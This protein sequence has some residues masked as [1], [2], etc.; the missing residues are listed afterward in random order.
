MHYTQL[1]SKYLPVV[2]ILLKRSLT[3]EQTLNLEKRDFERAGLAR[4]TGNKFVL[5][6]SNGRPDS[7]VAP[8][9]VKD[10]TEVLLQDDTV[11]DLFRQ[12]DYELTLNT[13]YQLGI[14]C[15]LRPVPEGEADSV[16]EEAAVAG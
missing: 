2:K 12:H 8:P 16:S 4:K 10:L 5:R 9:L 15:I 3:G 13:K 7:V 11:K 14:K 1:W 6:F